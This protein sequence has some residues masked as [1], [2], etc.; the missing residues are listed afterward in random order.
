MPL[1]HS[2][3]DTTPEV[4]EL[5]DAT[6]P[7][8]IEARDLWDRFPSVLRPWSDGCV[9][10]LAGVLVHVSLV[11]SFL[12]VWSESTRYTIESTRAFIRD[13]LVID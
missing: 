11:H 3:C 5:I 2:T 12:T 8:E 6:D 1:S 9:T 4:L 13:C 10:L 7:K